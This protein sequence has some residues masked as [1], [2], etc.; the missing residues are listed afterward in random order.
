MLSLLFLLPSFF[1]FT[2]A[3]TLEFRYHN[4][5]EIEQYLK[6]VSTSNPD[7]THLYSIG[8]SSK[9]NPA[10]AASCPTCNSET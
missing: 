7:I 6:Q 1:L 5:H 4:N 3:W 2:P 9:G 10:P 8:Q